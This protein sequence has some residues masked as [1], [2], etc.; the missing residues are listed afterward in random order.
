MSQPFQRE[1][2]VIWADLDPNGHMRHTAYMDYGAQVRLAFLDAHGFTMS[3][4]QKLMV[5]PVLFREYTDYI[6]EVRANEHITVTLELTGLSENHKHWAFRHKVYKQN[7]ELA[8]V[9]NVRGAWLSL[10]ERRIVPA[11]GELEQAVAQIPRAEDFAPI[12]GRE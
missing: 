1:Y 2:D 6:R 11:P 10:S 8:A 7:G 4:F 12:T 9:I 5:G 3:R